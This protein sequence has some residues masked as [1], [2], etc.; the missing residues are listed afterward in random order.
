MVAK[1]P[2]VSQP[3]VV[4]QTI[5]RLQDHTDAMS[6]HKCNLFGFNRNMIKTSSVDIEI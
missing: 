6:S 4:G 3:P 5:R 2:V 1:P